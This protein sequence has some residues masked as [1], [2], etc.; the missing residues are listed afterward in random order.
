MTRPGQ[1]TGGVSPEDY[2]VRPMVPL[3]D[4]Q[5]R[6]ATAAD[7]AAVAQRTGRSLT[8][9]Q[10]D[11]AAAWTLEELDRAA[12]IAADQPA[13]KAP[14]APA[15]RAPTVATADDPSGPVARKGAG[16]YDRSPLLHASQAPDSKWAHAVAR[17]KRILEGMVPV[18]RRGGQGMELDFTAS[19]ATAQ[20]PALARR[21]YRLWGNYL[22]RTRKVRHNPFAGLSDHDALRMFESEV[23]SICDAS[24]GRLGQ[25]WVPR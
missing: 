18:T 22:H 15:P 7:I 13:V 23:F 8:S 6:S 11:Q 4:A 10:A 19:T 12:R 16:R 3:T 9:R 5:L 1:L 2:V 14:A 25:W 21:Y 20:I 17:L 24:T